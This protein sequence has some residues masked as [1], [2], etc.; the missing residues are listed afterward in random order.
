MHHSYL[1]FAVEK[2]LSHGSF[3]SSYNS[4]SWIILSDQNLSKVFMTRLVE[5]AYLPK[6]WDK[7]RTFS[8]GDLRD[9]ISR[10][11]DFFG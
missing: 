8:A 5:L 6:S 3:L 1:P 2:T 10:A 11:L 4:L 9:E 7:G